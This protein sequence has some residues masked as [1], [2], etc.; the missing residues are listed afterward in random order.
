MK[1]LEEWF[2][3]MPNS[4]WACATEPSRLLV[5]DIDKRYDGFESLKTVEEVFGKLPLSSLIQATPSGGWHVVFRLPPNKDAVPSTGKLGK[6][7]E[8]ISRK[9]QFVVSPSVISDSLYE[10][11]VWI[12]EDPANA[13]RNVPVAPGWLVDFALQANVVERA[14][15]PVKAAQN[16]SLRGLAS[17]LASQVEGNR[18]NCLYWAARRARD[19][20]VSLSETLST[21]LPIAQSI[22]LTKAE[23]EATIKSAFK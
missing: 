8:I 9:G 6:G 12:E 10:S 13:I 21:F 4:N 17:Y 16:F 2:R 5:L 7:L 14:F 22:G 1:V 15:V 11:Y 23:S 20:G 19:H 3:R 18:N